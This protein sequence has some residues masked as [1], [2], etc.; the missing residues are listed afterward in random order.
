MAPTRID[1]N[2]RQRMMQQAADQRARLDR[3]VRAVHAVFP[4]ALGIVRQRYGPTAEIV[5]GPWGVNI[6]DQHG[7]LGCGETLRAAMAVADVRMRGRDSAASDTYPRP[8]GVLV[9]ER[10]RAEEQARASQANNGEF[11][12][13]APSAEPAASPAPTTF[14]TFAEASA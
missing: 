5:L 11:A 7:Q 1:S 3:N 4:R 10:Q 14:R 2:P 13:T 12:S 8:Y 9:A 6:I